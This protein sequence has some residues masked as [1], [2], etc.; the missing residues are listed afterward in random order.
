M[1]SQEDQ[2]SISIQRIGNGESIRSIAYDLGLTR[3][4]LSRQL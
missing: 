1:L 3:L 2:Y 4:T